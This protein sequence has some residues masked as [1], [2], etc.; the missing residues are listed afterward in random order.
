MK[1]TAMIGV[2]AMVLVFGFVG[3]GCPTGDDPSGAPPGVVSFE[4]FNPPSIWVENLTNERLVAFKGTVNP[5]TLISGI[6]ALSKKHGL[7]K[8]SALFDHTQTFALMLVKEDDYIANKDNPVAAPVF[9]RLFAFYKHSAT[10]SDVLQI[11]S[12]LGGEGKLSVINPL[13]Y[14]IEIKNESPTGEVLGYAPAQ[15]GQG[16]IINVDTPATYDIYPV[17]VFYNQIT[18][19]LYKVTPKSTSG[20]PYMEQFSFGGNNMSQTLNLGKI[21]EQDDLGLSF[22]GVLMEIVNDSSA[23]VTFRK[24]TTNMIS[25]TGIETINAGSR[26]KFALLFDM[27]SDGTYPANQFFED[28]SINA[29]QLTKVIDR[30]SYMLD[31]NFTIYVENITESSIEISPVIQG[32]QI[33]LD[34]VFGLNR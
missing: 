7:K 6:P 23:P 2:L 13:K 18:Q 24:G 31:Y 4:N 27:N 10:N 5:N 8:D 17:F 25:T 29:G 34:A 1:K 12:K 14:N 33:D 30:M 32:S 26:E 28:L 9:A 11:S 19:E 15:M 21:P 16:N 3:M 22:G 20:N